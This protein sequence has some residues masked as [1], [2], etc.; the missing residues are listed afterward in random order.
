VK[1]VDVNSLALRPFAQVGA[2]AGEIGFANRWLLV[3]SHM[4]RVGDRCAATGRQ[5]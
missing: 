5:Q 1:D 2:V 3:K 4:D